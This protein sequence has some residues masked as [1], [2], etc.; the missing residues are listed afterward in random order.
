MSYRYEHVKVTRI[1]DGDTIDVE[2]DFGMGI[3][4]KE[5]VRIAFIDAPE[6]R[7][8]EKVKGYQAKAFV[9]NCIPVGSNIQL[10]TFKEKGK[11]G[12]YIGC[13]YFI[14][15]D[16]LRKSL[17]THMVEAGHAIEKEY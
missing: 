14:G 16:G 4:K 5:R 2:I 13:V 3:H 7:G 8:E 17:G 11:F 1:V 9:E 10:E 15:E 12:R 6:V